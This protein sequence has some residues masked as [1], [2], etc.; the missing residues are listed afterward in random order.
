MSLDA[1]NLT[2]FILAFLLGLCV[3]LIALRES[4]NVV[5]FY[6]NHNRALSNDV[7]I[8][9]NRMNQ[10]EKTLKAKQSSEK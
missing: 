2:T 10:V 4:Y 7:S 1:R 8:L 6:A 3:M 9:V 5:M